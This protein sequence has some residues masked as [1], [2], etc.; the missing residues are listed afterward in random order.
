M[1]LAIFRGASLFS[2]FSRE[3]EVDW[4]RRLRSRGAGRA[5]STHGLPANEPGSLVVGAG[6]EDSG[7]PIAVVLWT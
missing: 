4:Q 5:G 3:T 7:D 2:T 1:L 6:E